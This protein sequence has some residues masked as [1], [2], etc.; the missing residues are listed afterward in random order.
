MCLPR[1]GVKAGPGLFC[2]YGLGKD[3]RQILQG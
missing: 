3:Y 1:N 2:Y